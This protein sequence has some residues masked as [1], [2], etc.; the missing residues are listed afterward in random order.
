MKKKDLLSHPAAPNPFSR[1]KGKKD[2]QRGYIVTGQKIRGG[3]ALEVDGYDN[4]TG[5]LVFRHFV[6]RKDWCTWN[7]VSQK[8][9]TYSLGGIDCGDGIRYMIRMEGPELL[10]LAEE[11]CRGEQ[12][13]ARYGQGHDLIADYERMLRI[14]KRDAAEERKR[15][16]IRIHMRSTPKLPRDFVGKCRKLLE[17][18]SK[19]DHI[20][21]TLF[22]PI[23]G[24]TK[25]TRIFHVSKDSITEICRAYTDE[26][27]MPWNEWYY[28]TR[29]GAY[30]R[31][32]RFWDRRSG[33][34]VNVLP[35]RGYVFDN[36]GELGLAP[37]QESFL[38]IMNG[39][40]DPADC[41]L[42]LRR[43][44]EIEKAAKA[45]FLRF[46][47]EMIEIYPSIADSI[48]R[49]LR[50]LPRQ[51]SRKLA[52][53]DAGRDALRILQKHPEITDDNLRRICAIRSGWKIDSIERAASG[54]NINHV[55]NLLRKTGGL[56]IK[57]AQKY[58]D[59]L[60]M[61][62]ARGSD[63]HDEIIY[64]D[65]HWQERHDTYVEENRRLQEE[66]NRRREEKK[67]REEERLYAQ[68]AADAG[69]N[70]RI[71][72][73]AEEGYLIMVPKN[74]EAINEE[75]RKQHHCVGTQP[76]YKERMARR[77]S[78][79]LFLRKADDPETPYYTIETDGERILQFYAKYDRQ[80][81]KEAVRAILDRWMKAVR[82]NMAK[83][84]REEGEEVLQA[85]G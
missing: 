81:D 21:V 55:M 13:Y 49:E 58:R 42:M 25:I 53:Y 52:E 5:E 69:R 75:G 12:I 16:K 18:E 23:P 68:I 36:L 60:E 28:G 85:A 77:K 82:R 83:I 30:G 22:Q 80:P 27:D 17:K 74:A 76:Q 46:T 38:R 2:G 48:L 24:R 64:R 32:Q 7:M 63:I 71:F 62:R 45:G 70:E 47:A 50:A 41:L 3:K 78:W 8:W 56:N 40:C 1:T 61:A 33:S 14:Y 43:Q 6:D 67:K 65:K 39:L 19:A 79:I 31:R 29:W 35:R 73:W 59:Y 44:P 34:V 20:H 51:Q 37:A 9:D 72:G 66:A 54:L 15:Q 57:T 84:L 10:P 26:Y 11:F 4:V